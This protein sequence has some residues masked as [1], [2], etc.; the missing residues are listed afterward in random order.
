VDGSGTVFV[1][2]TGNNRVLK[3]PAGYRGRGPRRLVRINRNHDPIIE[4][5]RHR[6]RHQPLFAPTQFKSEEG[7]PTFGN[8]GLSSATP[9]R[10]GG[11]R[12]GKPVSSQPGGESARRRQ[13]LSE[14]YPITASKSM[15]ADH[16][17]LATFNKLGLNQSALGAA[18]LSISWS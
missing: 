10:V 6:N 5:P 11:D 9:R 1:T 16:A 14:P 8:A 7:T 13:G 2:D 18:R 4:F 15:A 3:L 12:A 17:L